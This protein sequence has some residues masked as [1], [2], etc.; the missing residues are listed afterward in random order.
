MHIMFDALELYFGYDFTNL[1]YYIISSNAD[2]L[3][4]SAVKQ[5]EAAKKLD[6]KPSYINNQ[7]DSMTQAH[8]MKNHHIRSTLSYFERVKHEG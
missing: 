1:G 3:I 4:L 7:S 5:S 6:Y 2:T 8:N